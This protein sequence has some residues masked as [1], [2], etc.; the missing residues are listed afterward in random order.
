MTGRR[1]RRRTQTLDDVK[2]RRV[3][4]KLKKDA[5]DR[6]LCRSRCGRGY[7]QTECEA[8]DSVNIAE[9]F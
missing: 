6:T 3:Y 1:G 8:D 5:L 7:G 9:E 4:W 2:E